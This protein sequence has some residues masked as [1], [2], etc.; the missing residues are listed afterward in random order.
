MLVGRREKPKTKREDKNMLNFCPFC[1]SENIDP[2]NVEPK[3][4]TV[5]CHDCGRVFEIKT[6]GNISE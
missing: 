6:T 3:Y 4:S 2:T 5:V 1:A